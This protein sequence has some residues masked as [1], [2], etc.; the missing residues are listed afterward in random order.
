[1]ERTG[2]ISIVGGGEEVTMG[3]EMDRGDRVGKE[4]LLGGRV[5]SGS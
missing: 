1:M 5:C 3:G 2:E 4:E